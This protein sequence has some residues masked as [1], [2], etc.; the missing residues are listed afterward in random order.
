MPAA[1]ARSQIS[2]PH[3][4]IN[5][6]LAV[7]T[8]FLCAMA[9]SMISRATVGA[10]HQ[11]GD[12]VHFRMRHHLAPVRGAKNRVRRRR[13]FLRANRPAAQRLHAQLKPQLERDLL[14]VLG[15]NRE[16]A[17]AHVPQPDDPDVDLLHLALLS[18][19]E[20]TTHKQPGL[21]ERRQSLVFESALPFWGIFKILR[22][23]AVTKGSA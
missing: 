8:D 18:G 19:I 13:Q 3:S 6:L 1:I 12:D 21:T 7:T 15:E 10:A 23:R 9:P 4:A 5:S 16:R 2:A 20:V 11:L 14:G 22:N 17:R